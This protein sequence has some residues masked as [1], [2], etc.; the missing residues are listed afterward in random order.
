M[1]ASELSVQ[2]ETSNPRRKRMIFAVV[3]GV[4]AFGIVGAS[5]AS[6]GGITGTGLGADVGVVASCDTDGV[7]V[8]FVNG[9]DPTTGTYRTTAVNVTAIN[10]AC[11]GDAISLTLK[12]AADASLGGGSSTV[13]GGTA[14]ITL[15]TAA[16][17]S[18]VTGVA[19]VING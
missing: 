11:N 18:A 12:D 6:L 15:G 8:D 10:A 4:S 5:A 7:A 16:S 2:S 13:A 1:S 17:S 19:I 3:C 14:T 9:Y